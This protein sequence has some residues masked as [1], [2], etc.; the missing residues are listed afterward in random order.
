MHLFVFFFAFLFKGI[1]RNKKIYMIENAENIENIE[2][3][4]LLE[5]K[6]I[7]IAKHAGRDERYTDNTI[8]YEILNKIRDNLLK[9]ELLNTLQNSNISIF[10]KNILLENN[11]NFFIE[12]GVMSNITAGGLLDNFFTDITL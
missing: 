6:K 12:T 11:K 3:E 10:D 4:F 2:N 1:N 5:M 9:L 7:K 8:N